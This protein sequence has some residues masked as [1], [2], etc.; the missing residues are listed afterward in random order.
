MRS[1]FLL[2]TVALFGIATGGLHPL[3]SLGLTKLG[4]GEIIVGVVTAAFYVGAFSGAVGCRNLVHLLG[5]RRSFFAIATV[6]SVSTAALS[7]TD[8]WWVW[9][10]LRLLAG[11]ALGAYYVAVESWIVRSTGPS[12]RN[13]NLATYETVR[14]I[15]V[16]SG[17]LILSLAAIVSGYIGAALAMGVGAL[18]LLLIRNEPTLSLARESTPTPLV[19]ISLRVPAALAACLVA[20]VYAGSFYGLGALFVSGLGWTDAGVAIFMT[21][22]LLAPVLT[23]VPLGTLADRLGRRFLILLISAVAVLIGTVLSLNV[24]TDHIIITA[25]AMLFGGACYPLY[26]LG[27]GLLSESL[28]PDE[29]LTGNGLTNIAYNIGAITGPIAAGSMMVLFG[30]LG[31]YVFLSFIVL[32]VPLILLA[33]SEIACLRP[34]CCPHPS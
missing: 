18:P 14:L 26:A 34:G 23:Q 2:P 10:I 31:L 25:L 21:T 7:L 17:P 33:T 15:A 13:M 24:S 30:P 1:R 27:F 8:V 19:G 32:L 12:Q 11:C 20:G 28:T 6:A 4:Q 9:M 16:A 3:V 29:L 5:Y 22:V